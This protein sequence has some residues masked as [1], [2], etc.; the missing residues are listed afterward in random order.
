M[1]LAHRASAATNKRRV[2]GSRA[3]PPPCNRSRHHPPKNYTKEVEAPYSKN[4]LLFLLLHGLLLLAGSVFLRCFGCC[5]LR[6]GASCLFCNDFGSLFSFVYWSRVCCFLMLPLTHK[7]KVKSIPQKHFGAFAFVLIF[8]GT[9]DIS[10]SCLHRYFTPNFTFAF[11]FTILKVINS[12][13]PL[14]RMDYI[15]NSLKMLLCELCNALHA[16]YIRLF[17]ELFL[18]ILNMLCSVHLSAANSRV[19]VLCAPKSAALSR[20]FALCAPKSAAISR[21]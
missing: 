10:H 6:G 19:V 3:E 21:P 1:L 2:S 7:I 13:I 20:I 18:R 4:S 14:D 15:S 8:I 16:H 5:F 11:A 17:T 9:D 12:E